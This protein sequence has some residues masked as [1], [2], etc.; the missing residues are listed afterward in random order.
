MKRVLKWPVPVD[1]H[2]HPIGAGKVVH[3]DCAGESRV[4]YVWTEQ[5]ATTR[6]TGHGLS[7][8]RVYGTGQPIP[9]DAEHIGS[10]VTAGGMLV[11]HV[12]ALPIGSSL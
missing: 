11:W 9:D 7:S 10:A 4:V 6:R 12:Y 1:D 5:H 3:V 8:A 2:E